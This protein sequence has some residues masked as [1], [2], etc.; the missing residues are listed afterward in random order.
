MYDPPA[1][2]Q[3]QFLVADCAGLPAAARLL[4]SAP[5]A[6]RTRAVLEVPDAAHHLD[7]AVPPGV[8]ISWIH[9]GNGHGP[10]RLEQVVRSLPRPDGVGYVWVAGETRVARL[11]L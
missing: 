8:E 11:G 5:P 4:E 3:W 10:S 6:V 9:G 2:L 1:G 7:L